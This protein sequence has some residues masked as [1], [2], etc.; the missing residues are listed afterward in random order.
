MRVNHE[1]EFE[2]TV[3]REVPKLAKSPP[4][5]YSDNPRY[6]VLRSFVFP[7]DEWRKLGY[8]HRMTKGHVEGTG[9]GADRANSRDVNEDRCWE[10]YLN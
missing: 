3:N 9:T 5:N 10:L 7:R 6:S 1:L 8:T 2:M 4:Q